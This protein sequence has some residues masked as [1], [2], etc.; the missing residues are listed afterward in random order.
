[1]T[2]GFKMLTRG[3]RNGSLGLILWFVMFLL[4]LTIF[5]IFRLWAGIR[6]EIS[7]SRT[8][9]RLLDFVSLTLLSMYYIGSLY[10]VPGFTN[11]MNLA[12]VASTIIQLEN[13]RFIMKAH[14]FVRSNV[15]KVLAFKPNANETLNLPK[16]SHILY[17]SFAPTFLY[18]D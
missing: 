10:Y 12:P 4:H 6:Q 9:K 14:S 7:F 2:F 3:F 17:F 15:T 16:F 13:L 11:R 5:G 18:Q 1:P 8:L